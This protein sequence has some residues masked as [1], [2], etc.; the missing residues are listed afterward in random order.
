MRG[1]GWGESRTIL[2]IRTTRLKVLKSGRIR[3]CLLWRPQERMQLED[4]ATTRLASRE[5][6]EG[7][8]PEHPGFRAPLSTQV[9]IL[10][11]RA[12]IEGF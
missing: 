6:A 5:A 7:A 1:R 9:F 2:G 8:G 10:S 11:R 3:T 4:K 12:A